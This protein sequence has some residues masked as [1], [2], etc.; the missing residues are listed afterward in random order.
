MSLRVMKQYLFSICRPNE[1]EVAPEP[2]RLK[3]IMRNMDALRNSAMEAGI[4]VFGGGLSPPSTAT[5]VRLNGD[6]LLMTDGPF[7]EGKE[8]IGG[9]FVLRA[10]D[11]DEALEW[12]RRAA[13]VV[14]PLPIEVRPFEDGS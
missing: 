9:F 6:D 12:A 10:P 7:A 3:V 5:V 11:L 8:Y 2:A 14:T 1:G 4:W 13:S